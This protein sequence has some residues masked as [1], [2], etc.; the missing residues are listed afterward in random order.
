MKEKVYLSISVIIGLVAAFVVFQHF[1]PENFM[2]KDTTE[3]SMDDIQSNKDTSY[4]GH[5]AGKDIPRISGKEDFEDLINLD[6]V[7]VEPENIIATGVSNLKAWEDPY[8]KRAGTR[9]SGAGSR[10]RQI[11]KGLDLLDRYNEYYLLEC[12]DGTYILAQMPEKIVKEIQKGKKVTLPVS[13]KVS[14]TQEAQGYLTKICEKYDA[15]MKGVLYAFDDEWYQEHSTVI[16]LI[17]I[18]VSFV[19]LVAIAAVIMTLLQKLFGNI[20]L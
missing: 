19:V 16:F 3:I 13:S 10:R 11:I 14:I 20:D 17:R 18:G 5:P 7:T 1:Y 2:K 6:K 12:P 9:G 8:V 15:T 4:I